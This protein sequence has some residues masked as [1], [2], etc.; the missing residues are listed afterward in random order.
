MKRALALITA[1]TLVTSGCS[2]LRRESAPSPGPATPS[3]SGASASP[4]AQVS[5]DPNSS[6]EVKARL[7]PKPGKTLKPAKG[8]ETPKSVRQMQALVEDAR[9]LRF[10]TDVSTEILD[11][12]A[13]RK[14]L[15]ASSPSPDDDYLDAQT[16]ML[17]VMG[18][19]PEGTNLTAAL[20]EFGAAQVI[21]F[22]D[23]ATDEMVSTGGERL[24]PLD[25][26]TLAHELVHALEDQNFNLSF[27]DELSDACDDDAARAALAVAE[28]SATAYS[29][30]VVEEHFT[31]EDKL[32]IAEMTTDPGQ[33]FDIPEGVPDF[34]V[35]YLTWPYLA[36][37]RFVEFRRSRGGDAA[38]DEL[39]V[40]PPSSTEQILHPAKYGTDEPQAV[41]VP[42]I[43]PELGP[44]WK[45]LAVSEAGEDFVSIYLQQGMETPKAQVAASGWDG[46][47]A[48]GWSYGDQAVVVLGTAWDS[49]SEAEQFGSAARRFA[50]GKGIPHEVLQAGERVDV[51]YAT[52]GALV[53][54]ATGAL[55]G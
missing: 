6:A 55:S 31:A 39:F 17:E 48:R 53:E 36:G 4:T 52:S 27:I 51:V 12:A 19:V 10:K 5:P 49:Q 47:T 8:G 35:D 2:M 20:K 9:Q 41:D 26:M 40:D 37:Y 33:E 32:K 44:G 30:R 34:I 7:C 24:T 23:P 38:V 16:R 13:F 46:G 43:A 54:D 42:D 21:G 15:L 50:E 29:F 22:Y 11:L 14:R 25:R 18:A 45:D 28:G 1:I 3:G